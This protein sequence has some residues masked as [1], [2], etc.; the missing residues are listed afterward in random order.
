MHASGSGWL[1]PIAICGCGEIEVEKSRHGRRRHGGGLQDFGVR[2][3]D[4]GDDFQDVMIEFLSLI[5]WRCGTELDF[6][7]EMFL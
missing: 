3:F 4:G 5:D 1:S 7:D 2:A 6:A